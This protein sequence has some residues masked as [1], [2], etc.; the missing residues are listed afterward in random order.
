MSTEERH[1]ARKMVLWS[2]LI[3]LLPFLLQTAYFLFTEPSGDWRVGTVFAELA[4]LFC[5]WHLPCR[6]ETKLKLAII[7]IPVAA[8][9]LYIYSFWFIFY[10]L[11]HGPRIA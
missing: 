3:P 9:A 1:S 2:L 6:L 8:I 5:V 7:F 11:N 10:V 4:G